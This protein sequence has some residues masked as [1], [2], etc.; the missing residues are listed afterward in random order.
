MFA[1][2]TCTHRFTNCFLPVISFKSTLFLVM[3]NACE[4]TRREKIIGIR[5]NGH[6]DAH[7]SQKNPW[8][9]KLALSNLVQTCVGDEA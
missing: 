4:P 6:T 7:S 5:F 3:K 1:L 9:I 2:V 8:Y